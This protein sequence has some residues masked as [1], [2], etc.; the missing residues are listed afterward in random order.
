MGSRRSSRVG[1]GRRGTSGI[2]E[3]KDFTVRPFRFFLSLPSSQQTLSLSLLSVAS[4][5]AQTS[6]QKSPTYSLHP[7][8]P[9]RPRTTHTLAPSLSI[10]V[11]LGAVNASASGGD[12]FRPPSPPVRLT[13]DSDSEEEE[14]LYRPRPI[15]SL[16]L[17]KQGMVAGGN[18]RQSRHFGSDSSSED[19]D[20]EVEEITQTALAVRPLLPFF[21][22]SPHY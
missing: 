9:A 2:R 7:P 13:N 16:G 17:N 21:P 4:P 6:A 18:A 3:R 19:N 1:N 14:E 10:P 20:S 15:S 11:G 12:W 8:S 22:F 5:V